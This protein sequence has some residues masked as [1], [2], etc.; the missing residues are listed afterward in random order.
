[1]SFTTTV[2]HGATVDRKI[3][4]G[5]SNQNA[6]NDITGTNT[7]V[8]YAVTIDCSENP[9]ETVFVRIFDSDAPTVGTTAAE[10]LLFGVAGKSDNEYPFRRGIPFA[11]GISVATV[12][13]PGGT[14][15]ADSPTGKVKVTL[16]LAA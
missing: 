14:N 10:L 5:D 2:I 8:I 12:I 6:E 4:I 9:G 11:T 7:P 13:N 16:E 15:G 1:M 3:V